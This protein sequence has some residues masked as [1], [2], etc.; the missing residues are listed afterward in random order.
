MTTPA[1]PAAS[2]NSAPP[3]G[4]PTEA[5][6]TTTAA[7]TAGRPTALPGPLLQV[8]DLRCSF[9]GVQAVAGAS[10]EVLPGTITALIGPN[11]AGKSTAVNAIAGDVHGAGGSVRFERQEILGKRPP[12]I[13]RLGIRRTFQTA[14]L[15]GRMT[16]VENLLMG[17]QPW[18][19]EHLGRAFVGRRRWKKEQG[20][21]VARAL[22]L[23]GEFGV[24]RLANQPAATLSGGQKRIVEIMRALM[25]DPKLLLLDEP[26]AGI[27]PTLVRTIGEHLVAMRERGVTML[28]IEHDLA[29]VEELCDPVVV[30]AQGTVLSQGALADLRRNQD[31]IS[32]YLAG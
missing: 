23:M 26:M 25:G 16:V 3:T 22:D 6:A 15:F 30:M 18:A 5:P 13:A 31:V 8:S 2:T 32:A 9:G 12:E 29:L 20:D 10:F 27:N 19:G 11:G 17:A 4:E 7:G 21:L 24:L 14:N 1:P 28:M